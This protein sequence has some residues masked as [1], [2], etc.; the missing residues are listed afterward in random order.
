MFE[1][2]EKQK[3]VHLTPAGDLFLRVD[4]WYARVA[5]R[6]LCDK[7]TLG[8]KERAWGVRPLGIILYDMWSGTMCLCRTHPSAMK[9]SYEEV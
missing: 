2:G 3:N 4:S 9:I 7:G 8:D 1:G 5:P 6:F